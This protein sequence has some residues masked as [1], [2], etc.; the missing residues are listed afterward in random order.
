MPESV[1]SAREYVDNIEQVFGK[2]LFGR[3]RILTENHELS[4]VGLNDEPDEFTSESRQSVS[5][6]NHNM[7][8]ITPHC[9]F[10]NGF[11]SFTSEVEAAP[12]V[13][14]DF[15]LRVLFA[16]EGD[17][18]F[19]VIFLLV[20]GHAAIADGGLLLLQSKVSIDVVAPLP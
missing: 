16:H 1:H 10:Q 15:G 5:V 6:G 3:E 14:D 7:D 18:S 9:S 20:A 2:L 8:A 4:T 11:K 12:D 17:L 19:E 13:F